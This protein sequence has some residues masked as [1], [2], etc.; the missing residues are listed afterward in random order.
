MIKF[1]SGV[2]L[3]ASSLNHSGLKSWDGPVIHD[4]SGLED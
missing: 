2:F 3:R 4:E 1:N